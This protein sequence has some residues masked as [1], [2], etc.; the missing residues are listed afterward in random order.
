MS[1]GEFE[2]VCKKIEGKTKAIF[3]HVLGEPLLHPSL[4]TFLKI[5]Q[6]YGLKVCITT[7][8]TLLEKCGGIILEKAS[9]VH[10]VSISLHC[11]E[12]NDDTGTIENY[13]TNCI[14]F[15]KKASE[16]GI[17]CV[18]RLW[19]M[20]SNEAKGKNSLNSMIED[21]L[22][23]AFDNEWTKRWSG[24]RLDKNVFL[25]YAGTFVWPKDSDLAPE[26]DG[27]CH[28]LVD[29]I[30]V[31]DVKAIYYRLEKELEV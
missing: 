16:K 18:F 9:A 8:G 14:D 6:K 1:E 13:L 23:S 5:A 20:D 28:G 19:N 10:R 22:H 31:D 30:D 26:D 3:L 21:T 17:Y 2:E 24:F 11:K 4:S 12:G 29:Y 27:Y 15:S 25:E 7:N